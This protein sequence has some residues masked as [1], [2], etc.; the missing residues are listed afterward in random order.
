MSAYSA[1]ILA[2]DPT[3]YYR[4]DETSGT[5]MVDSSGNGRNGTYPASG[6]TYGIPGAIENDTDTAISIAGSSTGV[7]GAAFTSSPTTYSVVFWFKVA[8]LTG[9]TGTTVES[10]EYTVT[11]TNPTRVQS[12]LMALTFASNTEL[13]M[14][15]PTGSTQFAYTVPDTNWH[16]MA[17][18]IVNNGPGSSVTFY[19]DGVETASYTGIF[20]PN[21]SEQSSQQI[22]AGSNNF[23]GSLD[24]IAIFPFALSH[25][26]ITTLFND[27]TSSIGTL[28]SSGAAHLVERATL[29][30]AGAAD[31]VKSSTMTANGAAAIRGLGSITASGAANITQHPPVGTLQAAGHATIHPVGFL[32][33]NGAATIVIPPIETGDLTANGAANILAPGTLT[34]G[35]GA[36]IAQ[37]PPVGTLQAEGAATI[38]VPPEGQLTADGAANIIATAMLTALGAATISSPVGVRHQRYTTAWAV[39]RITYARVPT[40]YDDPP[41]SQDGSS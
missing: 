12:G 31:I 7:K 19:A 14:K 30:A 3:E 33:A 40:P 20:G 29:T 24:E 4:L 32:T 5:T 34:A 28:T 13:A 22:V 21:G 6:V 18:V 1:A 9:N 16:Q 36:T 10:S 23:N 35:G 2:L 17:V 11:F 27:G 39:Q 25:T 8:S 37:Q 41:W 15:I 26:Q 38:Y